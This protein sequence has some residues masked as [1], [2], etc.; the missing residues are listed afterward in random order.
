MFS[1]I[2]SY[3]LYSVKTFKFDKVYFFQNEIH[4][5]IHIIFGGFYKVLSRWLL[6]FRQ[7][8]FRLKILMKWFMIRS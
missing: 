5:K 2:H 6:K 7:K 8:L 1:N 4:D 3:E